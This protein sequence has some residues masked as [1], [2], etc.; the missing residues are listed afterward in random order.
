VVRRLRVRV[1]GTVDAAPTSRY[2][3]HG[4][5]PGRDHRG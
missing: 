2:R 1:R 5:A 4:T 3:V